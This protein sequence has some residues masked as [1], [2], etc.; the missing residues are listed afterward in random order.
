MKGADRYMK[1]LLV[2]F[3]SEVM[4]S[5]SQVNIYIRNRYC[6]DIMWCLCGG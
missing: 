2:I 4:I 5:L 3:N 6:M 1:I